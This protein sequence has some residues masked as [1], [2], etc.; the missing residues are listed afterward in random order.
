MMRKIQE[1]IIIHRRKNRCQKRTT[2]FAL[3]QTGVICGAIERV[4]CSEKSFRIRINK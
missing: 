1:I 4:N 2:R 3:R